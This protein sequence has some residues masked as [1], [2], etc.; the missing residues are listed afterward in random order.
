MA[1]GCSYATASIPRKHNGDSV[2][3]GNE[4]Y[5]THVAHLYEWTKE[6][7]SRYKRYIVY[8]RTC[9]VGRSFLAVFHNIS[10]QHYVPPRRE[11]HRVA[12]LLLI[13]TGNAGCS[14]DR[15]KVFVGSYCEQYY[16]PR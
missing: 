4:S 2:P 11:R 14:N 8:P 3:S 6:M 15:I 1:S 12:K 13:I 7:H 5:G 16:D 10:Y 9:G